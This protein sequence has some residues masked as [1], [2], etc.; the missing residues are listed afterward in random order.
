MSAEDRIRDRKIHMVI[1]PIFAIAVIAAVIIG[2]QPKV[3]DIVSWGAL[4]EADV[5]SGE[6]LKS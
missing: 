2:G 6:E 3:K 1:V 4:G 5:V